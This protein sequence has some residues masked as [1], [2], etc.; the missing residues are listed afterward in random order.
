MRPVP[1]KLT[2]QL[3]PLLDLLLIVIF[4]QFM[5]MRDESNASAAKER[6]QAA[7]LDKERQQLAQLKKSI[8]AQSDQ[9][10]DRIAELQKQLRERENSIKS[11]LEKL[12]AQ[13]DLLSKHLAALFQ[14]PEAALRKTLEPLAA[15]EVARTAAELKRLEQTVKSLAAGGTPRVVRHVIK[16]EELLK[17]CDIWEIHVDSKSLARVVFGG[18]KHDFRYSAKPPLLVNRADADTRRQNKLEITRYRKELQEDFER[19]LFAYY[20]NL[21]QL[22]NVVI[23]L[24]S[25]EKDTPLA[26]YDAAKLGLQQAADH[27]STDTG[28]RITVVSTDLGQLKYE[29]AESR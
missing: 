5:E 26:T 23:I 7:S 25:R 6:E 20:K 11:R 19:K 24:L 8:G 18:K 16:Y 10:R 12:T 28:A 3:T 4:A 27:I 22:K 13:R 2:M 21:P 15:A 17:R 29:S 14:V 1:R 9:D